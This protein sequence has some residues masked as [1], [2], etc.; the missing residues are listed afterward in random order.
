MDPRRF[1]HLCTIFPQRS[2][3]A[4]RHLGLDVLVCGRRRKHRR[5]PVMTESAL[6]ELL[7][8]GSERGSRSPSAPVIL[9]GQAAV[10][11]SAMTTDLIPPFADDDFHRVLCVVAHPD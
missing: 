7:A 1:R 2:A 6:Q 4:R 8:A 10:T 5:K 9:P 11:L 3:A